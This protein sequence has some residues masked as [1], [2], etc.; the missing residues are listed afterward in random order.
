MT[1]LF[2]NKCEKR[3]CSNCSSKHVNHFPFLADK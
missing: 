1:S 3:M 2:C